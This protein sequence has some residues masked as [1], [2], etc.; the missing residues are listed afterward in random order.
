MK[1]KTSILM[2]Y[3]S[4][5]FFV[6]ACG[7]KEKHHNAEMAMS[8]VSTKVVEK[9]GYRFILDLQSMEAHMKMMKDMGMNMSGMKHEGNAVLMLT[10]MDM[11][12]SKMLQA[13]KVE[14]VIALGEG[15]AEAKTAVLM[16]EKGMKHYVAMLN[17]QENSKLSV[18]ANVTLGDKKLEV[19]T[20]F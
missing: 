19:R 17:R 14:F 8:G 2:M 15:K 13:D 9:D 5:A 11:E 1:K 20:E 4:A 7:E 3:M 12:T 6:N 16:A 18:S 10:I